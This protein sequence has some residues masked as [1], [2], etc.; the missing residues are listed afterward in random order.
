[1][2]L[3]LAVFMIGVLFMSK[4]KRRASVEFLVFVL[5][6]FI[7]IFFSTLVPFLSNIYYSLTE[8]DGVNTPTFIGLSNFIELFTDDKRLIDS[9]IFTIKYLIIMVISTNVL[10][11][12]LALLLN[13]KIRSRNVLRTAFFLPYGLSGLVAA[14][15][16]SFIFTVGFNQLYKITEISFFNQGWLSDPSLAWL[17][18]AFVDLWKNIGY[19]M[20]IYIAGLQGISREL[21]ESAKVDGANSVQ[22]FFKVVLPM[23]M[24]TI[25]ICLFFSMSNAL[26]TFDISYALTGGGPGYTTTGMPQNIYKEAFSN[27]RYGYA[28]AKS[29]VYF[30]VVLI[31]SLF[32]LKY[33]QSKEVE[34]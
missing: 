17:S 15:M 29:L 8:W 20:I 3:A 23:L 22:S 28:S 9:F 5:P 10:G 6:S 26:N 32:Q 33:T 2:Q 4:R 14:M 31:F 34:A 27:M 13:T 18:V 25:T 24:P 30:V 16:F 1:M 12:A 11:L 21:T 7:L 19:F